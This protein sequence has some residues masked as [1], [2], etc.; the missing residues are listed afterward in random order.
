M[1]PN[2]LQWIM[3]R[4]SAAHALGRQPVIRHGRDDARPRRECRFDRGREC[5]VIVTWVYLDLGHGL[6]LEHRCHRRRRW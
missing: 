1:N 3:K 6:G 2:H 5:T 4:S